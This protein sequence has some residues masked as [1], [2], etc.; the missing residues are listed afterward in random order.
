MRLL[1]L[2]FLVV[3]LGGCSAVGKPDFSCPGYADDPTCLN[4][5][6]VYEQSNDRDHVSSAQLKAE[7]QAQAE[8]DKAGPPP[9]SPVSPEEE[10]VKA[11]R[12]DVPIPIRTPAQVMRVWF[13]PWVDAQGSLHT[14]QYV[15]TEIEKRRWFMGQTPP[16]EAGFP[17]LTPLDQPQAEASGAGPQPSQPASPLQPQ[18]Q[19]QT[20]PPAGVLQGGKADG[21]QRSFLDHGG[22]RPS[23]QQPF[24]TQGDQQ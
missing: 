20:Q 8:A 5:R 13:A 2:A 6:T 16:V 1:I 19:P 10:A 7:R 18:G 4:A 24:F 12:L 22:N 15:F 21:A 23:N 14:Q 9:A 3:L 17:A 11:L